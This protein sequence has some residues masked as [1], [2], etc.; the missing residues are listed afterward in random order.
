MFSRAVLSRLVPSL[1]AAFC[2]EVAFAAITL[3]IE[4]NPDP[5]RAL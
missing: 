2:S 1:A 4:M 5:P 3:D